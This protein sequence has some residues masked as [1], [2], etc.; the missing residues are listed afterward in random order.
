MKY[1]YCRICKHKFKTGDVRASYRNKDNMMRPYCM[2][3]WRKYHEYEN[4]N[5]STISTHGVN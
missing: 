3:C 2:I 5:V 4:E 1:T